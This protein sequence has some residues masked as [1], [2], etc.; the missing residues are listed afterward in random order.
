MAGFDIFSTS[1]CWC[2]YLLDR[3]LKI[4]F[5]IL[6]L[7]ISRISKVGKHL[8]QNGICIQAL[9]KL[10]LKFDFEQ[11]SIELDTTAVLEKTTL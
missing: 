10:G 2:V 9:F 11:E 7:T 3:V 4:Y 8:F 1:A 5:S 6:Y